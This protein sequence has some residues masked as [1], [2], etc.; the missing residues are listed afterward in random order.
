MADRLVPERSDPLLTVSV[1]PDAHREHQATVVLSGELD[2][3][4]EQEARQAIERLLGH[5]V[6][7]LVMDLRRLTFIDSSGLNLLT[8]IH[9]TLNGRHGI[10]A[11][12]VCTGAVHRV[13]ELVRLSTMVPVYGTLESALADLHLAPRPRSSGAHPV[14]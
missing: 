8:R 13:L 7:C 1:L 12:V 11:L 10:L 3:S 2:R 4:T 5:D 9:H 14:H 6:R